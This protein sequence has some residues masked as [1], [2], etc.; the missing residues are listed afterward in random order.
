MGEANRWQDA[1]SIALREQAILIAGLIKK[2]AQL[3]NQ[4]N[5]N[6]ETATSGQEVIHG[7]TG[8]VYVAQV[9]NGPDGIPHKA[10]VD[11]EQALHT[12]SELHAG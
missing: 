4:L 11:R 8:A 6:T 12:T 10:D 3:E 2:V 1:F 9:F 7:I 5:E